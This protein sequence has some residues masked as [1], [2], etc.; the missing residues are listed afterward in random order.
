MTFIIG[1][2]ASVLVSKLSRLDVLFSSKIFADISCIPR[3]GSN[4]RSE[5]FSKSLSI[6]S[7]TECTTVGAQQNDTHI[8]MKRIYM[9]I[10]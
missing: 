2:E 7:K 9:S 1:V 6:K 5:A 8:A 10:E 3:I 4:K